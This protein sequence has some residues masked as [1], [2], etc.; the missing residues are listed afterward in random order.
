VVRFYRNAWNYVPEEYALSNDCSENLKSNI[1]LQF[2]CT[3]AIQKVTFGELLSNT[4]NEE[5]Y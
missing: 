3:R 4:S 2:I 1:E 5:K